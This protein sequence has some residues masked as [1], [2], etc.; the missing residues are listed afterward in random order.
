MSPALANESAML[1]QHTASGI[2]R[3]AWHVTS[4][5]SLASAVVLLSIFFAQPARG[6]GSTSREYQLKAAF[7]YNFTKFVDWP[8]QDFADRNTPIVIGV[9]GYNPFGVTLQD[10]VRGRRVNSRP[11]VVKSIQSVEAARSV[12]VLFVGAADDARLPELE[13]ACE[14]AGVLIV[15]ESTNFTKHGGTIGFTIAGDNLHFEINL[16]AAE[17][18]QLKISAQLLKLASNNR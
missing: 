3:N 18:A 2:A 12:Q 6:Q 4:L 9:F 17:A 10:S 11:I 14:G 16:A 13:K 7:L 8:H 1:N 5:N 15:G